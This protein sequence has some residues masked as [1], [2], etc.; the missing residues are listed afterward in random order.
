MA[1]IP[2]SALP[3]GDSAVNGNVVTQIEWNQLVTTLQNAINDNQAQI[4]ALD[5]TV[6]IPVM[7]APPTTN[8]WKLG[9]IVWNSS[10]VKGGNVGWVCTVAGTPGTW[11]PFGLIS[12]I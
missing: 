7:S 9:Q 6:A 10:P 11:T 8:T 4:L 5:P 1:N 2:D 3:F 12:T